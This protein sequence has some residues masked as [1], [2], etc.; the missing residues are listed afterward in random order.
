MC[1]DQH[2]WNIYTPIQFG[3]ITE[4]NIHIGYMYVVQ[5]GTHISMMLKYIR[6]LITNAHIQI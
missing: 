6:P 3:C 2:K 1:T 4:W 5:H